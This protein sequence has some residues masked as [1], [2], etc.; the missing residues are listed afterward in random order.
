MRQALTNFIAALG[1][2]YDGDPRIGF[3]TVGLLGFWGEWHTYPHTE[4]FASVSVQDRV[5][6]ACTNAFRQTRLLRRYPNKTGSFNPAT[7]PIGYHDDSFAY[8]TIAPPSWH[9]LGQMAEAGETNKWRTQPIGGE[10]RPEVQSLHVGHEPIRT[11]S[12]PARISRFV[13]TC[14]HASWMLNHGAF[15][16]G[17]TGDQKTRAVA[18]SARL[19]YE[20][21]VSNA[22]LVDAS[23]SGSLRVDLQ[24]RNAGVAPFYYDWPVQLGARNS[25]NVLVKTWTTTWKLSSLLPAATNTLW[26]WSQAGHGLEAGPHKLLLR[27]QNPLTNGVPF[28]FAN[29]AQDADLPGWLTLGQVQIVPTPARPSLRGSLSGSVFNLTVSNAAPGLVDRRGHHQSDRLDSASLHQH[30]HAELERH[31]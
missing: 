5:L 13:W 17:F 3:I 30:E 18:G 12:R 10:V 31:G 2:R 28:R 29:V 27:V 7:L 6:A 26:T 11:A 24:L 25:N 14:T 22:V 19:G 15:S 23:V 21:Y 9:F 20:L 4:W 1:A 16:P 8:S